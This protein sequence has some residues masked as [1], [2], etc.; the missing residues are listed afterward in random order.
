MIPR[1]VTRIL[2]LPVTQIALFEVFRD[3]KAA[4]GTQPAA[5][6]CPPSFRFLGRQSLGAE[7]RVKGSNSSRRP[8]TLRGSG[9]SSPTLGRLASS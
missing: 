2:G 3:S 8:D 6:P 9:T 7:L 1:T 5:L 4:S